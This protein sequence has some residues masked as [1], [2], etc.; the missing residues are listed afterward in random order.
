MKLVLDRVYL[1]HFILVIVLTSKNVK[2]EYKARGCYH[3]VFLP[4]GAVC[5]SALCDCVIS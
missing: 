2:A 5:W 1:Y 3:S 4:H